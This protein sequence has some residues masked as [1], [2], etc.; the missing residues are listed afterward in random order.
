MHFP[1]SGKWLTGWSFHPKTPD[2]RGLIKET[3]SQIGVGKNQYIPLPANI[4]PLFNLL[5]C[6]GHRLTFFANLLLLH[7]P[8]NR[9]CRRFDKWIERL[10]SSSGAFEMLPGALPAMS[11]MLCSQ[12]NSEWQSPPSPHPYLPTFTRQGKKQVNALLFA[13]V[14]TM[15]L[16]RSLSCYQKVLSVLNGSLWLLEVCVEL[17]RRFRMGLGSSSRIAEFLCGKW[18]EP[19]ISCTITQTTERLY[20]SGSPSLQ[21]GYSFYW[22]LAD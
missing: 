16:S 6:F 18:I 9:D 20:D 3:V 12:S 22:S 1:A 14:G 11:D 7:L 15:R 13:L 5:K 4:P 10:S 19:L 2:Q 8:W 17:F 21:W